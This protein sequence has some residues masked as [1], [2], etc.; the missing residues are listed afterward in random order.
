MK[1]ACETEWNNLYNFCYLKSRNLTELQRDIN[2]R[3][4]NIYLNMPIVNTRKAGEFLEEKDCLIAKIIVLL[5]SHISMT[6]R[7]VRDFGS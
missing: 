4:S 3:V 5:E 7:E 2:E 1:F 6:R